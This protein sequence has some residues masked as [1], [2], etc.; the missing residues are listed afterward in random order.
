MSLSVCLSVCL[1]QFIVCMCYQSVEF[2]YEA[3]HVSYVVGSCR[4][5]SVSKGRFLW[6][7]TWHTSI[8][9]L[10]L[11][12]RDRAIYVCSRPGNFGSLVNYWRSGTPCQKMYHLPSLNTLFTA[13]SKL[14][15]FSRRLFLTSSS[16]T[17][18][19]LTFSLGLS[20]ATLRRFC[21][22][23][24]TNTIWYDMKYCKLLMEN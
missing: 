16:D 22:L 11:L 17:D 23:K 18:C 7:W 10:F 24:S 9:S 19:I 6:T 20:A 5:N 13:S 8:V 21:H 15:G 4:Q 14:R 3:G 1:S 12:S 2:Q